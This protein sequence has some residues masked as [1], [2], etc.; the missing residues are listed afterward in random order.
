M[1]LDNPHLMAQLFMTKLLGFSLLQDPFV[2]HGI[3]DKP[4]QIHCLLNVEPS[5]YIVLDLDV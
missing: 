3:K 5:S 4:I 1:V 2:Y